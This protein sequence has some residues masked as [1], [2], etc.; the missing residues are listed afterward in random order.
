[1]SGGF[2][3]EGEERGFSLYPESP[4]KVNSGFQIAGD[5]RPDGK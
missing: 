2:Y 1:M 3:F 5:E 4:F